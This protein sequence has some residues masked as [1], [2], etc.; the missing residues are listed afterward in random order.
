M[1]KSNEC[2]PCYCLDHWVCDVCSGHNSCKIK[3]NELA[4]EYDH[5]EGD[6]T[7]ITGL[8]Y[9]HGWLACE[10]RVAQPLEWKLAKVT[11]YLKLEEALRK[12]SDIKRIELK[13]QL[14]KTT[15]CWETEE[16][17]RS[18]CEK[19][20]TELEKQLKEKKCKKCACAKTKESA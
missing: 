2:K 8:N 3:M 20:I 9:S 18:N 13:T 15:K 10:E 19:R 4:H 5:E 16:A 6:G 11:K 12:G 14:K 17:L 7:G 1:K